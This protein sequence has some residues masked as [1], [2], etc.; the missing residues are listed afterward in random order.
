MKAALSCSC[1]THT[2]E[3]CHWDCE[4]SAYRKMQGKCSARSCCAPLLVLHSSENSKV[5]IKLLLLWEM[6]SGNR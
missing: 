2:T 4:V 5:I 1:E 3:D 6:C